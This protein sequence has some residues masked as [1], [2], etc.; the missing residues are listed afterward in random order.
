M[1]RIYEI[2][3]YFYVFKPAELVEKLNFS[4]KSGFEASIS[5]KLL[6]PKKVCLLIVIACFNIQQIDSN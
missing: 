1:M 4:K 3:D 5:P 2:F 6:D